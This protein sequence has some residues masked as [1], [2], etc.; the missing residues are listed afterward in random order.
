VWDEKSGKWIDF[1]ATPPAWFA[2][3]TPANTTAQKFN[4]AM[5]RLREDFFLWRNR[6]ANRLAASLVMLTI[7]LAIAA[8][9]AKRLWRSKR[10]LEAEKK[11]AGYAGAIVQTPL[12]GLERQAE[13]WLGARP[14]GQPLAA[15]LMRLHPS[16]PD[17]H[18]LEEAIDLHQRLRFDPDPPQPL[19]RERLAELTN[20]LSTAIR[21]R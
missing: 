20:Q 5:K 9:I 18:A 3:S 19:Q 8:F 21:H 14:Q 7:A 17:S 11:A 4:D 6:P 1:D 12:N 15:W 13:K 2:T 16:L 10:R